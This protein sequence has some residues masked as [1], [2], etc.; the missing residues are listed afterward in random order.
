MAFPLFNICGRMTDHI[1]TPPQQ[2]C[3]CDDRGEQSDCPV[4]YG[5][6]G[7]S[8]ALEP[9]GVLENEQ[10]NNKSTTQARRIA[11]VGRPTY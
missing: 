1:P 3:G 2:N 6:E 5:E 9:A 4:V 7:V 8:I 10:K 11:F